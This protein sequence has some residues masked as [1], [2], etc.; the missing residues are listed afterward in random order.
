M[1]QY[2]VYVGSVL[3]NT[4]VVGAPE[5]A[6]LLLT[7]IRAKSVDAVWNL[8]APVVVVTLEDG[9]RVTYAGAISVVEHATGDS[10]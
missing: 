3:Y 2:S 4:Y 6:T 10:K 5:F 1:K 9:S 8:P 7:L